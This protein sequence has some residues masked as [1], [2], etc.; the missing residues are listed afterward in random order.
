VNESLTSKP[1]S[2]AVPKST[3][4]WDLLPNGV[5]MLR[6]EAHLLVV[7]CDR[8]RNAIRFAVLRPLPHSRGLLH[9]ADGYRVTVR[10]AMT[11]AEWA[12]RHA[13]DATRSPSRST[14]TTSRAAP[15][16]T[17]RASAPA[18]RRLKRSA[19]SGFGGFVHCA[20]RTRDGD[21]EPDEAIEGRGDGRVIPLRSSS[22]TPAPL[23]RRASLSA[24]NGRSDV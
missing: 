20:R 14:R 15:G 21:G 10:G 12:A 4:N 17:G 9:V 18:T 6:T 7:R 11:A 13:L 19:D 24:S 5:L 8:E 16:E 1:L 2:R 3:T 23:S 22:R